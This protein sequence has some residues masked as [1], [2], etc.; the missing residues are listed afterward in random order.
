MLL[1]KNV[2][3]KSMSNMQAVWLKQQQKT[4]KRKHAKKWATGIMKFVGIPFKKEVS[5]DLKGRI[6]IKKIENHI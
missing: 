3:F 4:C 6:R 2:S 5:Q 1:L